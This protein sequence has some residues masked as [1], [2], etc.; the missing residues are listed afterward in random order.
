MASDGVIFILSFM[1]TGV[2]IQYILRLYIREFEGSA[3]ILMMGRIC[4]LPLIFRPWTRWC[5]Y[6]LLK[7]CKHRIDIHQHSAQSEM[8]QKEIWRLMCNNSRS[9]WLI[10]RRTDWQ[11]WKYLGPAE[12]DD[13]GSALKLCTDFNDGVWTFFYADDVKLRYPLPYGMCVEQWSL[14]K[15]RGG[16]EI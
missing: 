15:S 12:N 14:I 4:D 11:S 10:L 8:V 3:L 5:I 13:N 6:I 7:V 2:S 16:S 9:L 1:G